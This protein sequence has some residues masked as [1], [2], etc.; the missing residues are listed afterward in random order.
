MT[1]S[2]PYETAP[3]LSSLE[4]NWRATDSVVQPDIRTCADLVNQQRHGPFLSFA[5]E[6]VGLDP[7]LRISETE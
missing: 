1:L 3:F 4:A 2:V 7:K 6:N 5:R